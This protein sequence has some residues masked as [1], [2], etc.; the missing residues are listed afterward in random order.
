MAHG[1]CIATTC[2]LTFRARSVPSYVSAGEDRRVTRWRWR[3]R[4]WAAPPSVVH[5]VLSLGAALWLQES[6]WGPHVQGS[7]S[8]R[9]DESLHIAGSLG[10]GLG[11]AY[12][13]IMRCKAV[14]IWGVIRPRPSRWRMRLGWWTFPLCACLALLTP[15]LP[16]RLAISGPML[17][18]KSRE[19]VKQGRSD[20]APQWVGLYRFRRVTLWPG[21]QVRFEFPEPRWHARAILYAP[22]TA[23]D[24]HRPRLLGPLFVMTW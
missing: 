21:G 5:V 20:N 16:V 3:M 18:L 17:V 4:R 23:E 12:A 13:Y 9:D 19:V 11:L 2:W 24:M 6:V 1:V 14:S 22:G 15:V 8:L 7:E 10:V